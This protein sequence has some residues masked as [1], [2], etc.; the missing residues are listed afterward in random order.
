MSKLAEQV[1]A[2]VLNTR[3]PTSEIVSYEVKYSPAN[4]LYT[5]LDYEVRFE[6]KFGKTIFVQE[7]LLDTE[8]RENILKEITKS[9]IQTVFGEFRD[10]IRSIM[11]SVLHEESKYTVMDKLIDLEKQMFDV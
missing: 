3:R 2:T 6:A 5:N 4:S 8:V 1:K 10:P 9:V 7:S 11:H